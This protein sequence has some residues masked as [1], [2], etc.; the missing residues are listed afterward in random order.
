MSAMTGATSEPWTF[1]GESPTLAGA[2]PLVTL[3]EETSF[4]LSDGGGDI[5]PGAAHGLF[6]LDTRFLSA[7][8][9]RIDGERVESLAVADE[10]PFAATFF[11]R[12][13]R[14]VGGGREESTLVVFRR[15]HIGRGLIEK[16]EVRNYGRAPATVTV[17]LDVDA[18]FAD[19][20]AV[21]EGRTSPIHPGRW[22]SEDHVLRI[23]GAD[24]HADR[25][26]AVAFS[27]PGEVTPG[28]ARWTAE[29]PPHGVWDVCVE[30]VAS[31]NDEE[32]E[33]RHRCGQPVETAQP[34]RRLHAWQAA[35]PVISSDSPALEE[36]VRRAGEDL[37]ALRIEDPAHPDDVIIAAG[38]PWYM[39]VFGRDSL[40]TA[41]MALLVDPSVALGVLR[42]L[43][44]LQGSRFD[45][46]TEEEPGR[47][48]HEVRFHDRPSWSL[49]DGTIYYG[50]VDATP[51]FVM[52]L[53]ELRRWGLER[54]AVEELLPHAD[55]A[56]EWIERWGDRDGDGYVEYDRRTDR[57]LE[58]Q[59]WKDSWDAIRFADG[60]LAERPIALC[61]V[62]GY[63][64]AAYLARAYFADEHGETDL[65]GHYRDKA[66]KLKQAFNRDFWL[67]DKG[68]VA[69]ALDGSKR[70][71]DALS[72]NM[73]HC[74]WTGI[75][76]PDKS[77]AVADKLLAPELFSGW[78]VRTLATSMAAYNPVSY[79]NGSVWP[80]DNALIAAGLMRYGF[81]D[82]AHRII[83]ALLD[84]SALQDGRLPELFS[85]VDRSELP[86][87]APYPAS[88]QP[89]AWA[90]AAPLLFLRSLLRFDPWMVR[91]KLWVAPQLPS[92]ITRLAVSGIP[93]EDDRVAVAC[94]EREVRVSGVSAGIEVETNPR[95]PLTASLDG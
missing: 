83:R 59:G 54:D 90:A 88:C 93:L 78:G 49:G 41:Y 10:L 65:A 92:W 89:Q 87:P 29:L 61:E 15:R 91:R 9:L 42:T 80:H 3:V 81:T 28:R 23:T 71:V 94:H 17:E 14:P 16:V 72:S 62:Q 69:I 64:Y 5:L 8:V 1:A 95:H 36:A 52:L 2:R 20:F 79:H 57:G 7:L 84:V 32:I 60:P 21:K 12:V 76:D 75:L 40:L 30:V 27:R 22:S 55:R 13:K 4:C 39:T 18:D 58:N 66:A 68:Y 33:P 35:M 34:Q 45:P 44:R 53:G 56:L 85:G 70:P 11:G 38:A 74:L 73:G 46:E 63:V 43:A 26:V 47:I 77:A 86:V 6:F 50:T 51:L 48:L 19:L 67:A 24:R 31:L 37:G 82:H 25:G